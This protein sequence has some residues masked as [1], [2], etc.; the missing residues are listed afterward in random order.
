MF[1]QAWREEDA[2][3]QN[4]GKDSKH[5]VLALHENHGAFVNCVGNFHQ[6]GS[7]SVVSTNDAVNDDCDQKARSTNKRWNEGRSHLDPQ[8]INETNKGKS[9]TMR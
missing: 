1:T 9:V 4:Q 7:A 8:Q 2:R 5:R 3:K 6:L